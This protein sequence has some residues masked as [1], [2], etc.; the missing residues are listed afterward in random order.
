ME[1]RNGLKKGTLLDVVVEDNKIFLMGKTKLDITNRLSN[2]ERGDIVHL[3]KALAI[4]MNE[5]EINIVK[6]VQFHTHSEFSILDGMSKLSAIAKKS[7]GVTAVTDHGNMYALLKW[8][9]EMKK[10]GKKAIFGEE[11]YVET[12]DGK[13]E[14]NHLILLA[15]DEIGKKNL[16]LL[17]SEAFYAYQKKPHVTIENLKKYHEGLI[18]TS[19]CL[20]GEI[21]STIVSDYE[22]AKKVALFYKELFNEDFYLEIQ[23]HGATGEKEANIL[24]VKLARELGIKLVAANDSHYIDKSDQDS[25]EILLCINTGKKMDEPHFTFDGDGYWFKTDSEMVQDFWDLPEAITNTYEIA[26]KCNLTIETGVYHFPVFPTPEEYRSEEEF[27]LHL[28]DKGYNERFEGTPMFNNPE[29][30]NRLEHEKNVILSMG[31]VGYFL[32][33]WDYVNFA[34]NNGILVGPGRGSAAGSL[35]CY[36][37]KITDLEP[38]RHGLLFERFLNP[39]RLSMPDID[40]DFEYERRQEVIDYV[41]R[42]YGLDRVCNIITFGTMA[43]KSAV[44]DAA[45]VLSDYHLGDVIAK[46]IPAD[47]KNIKQA[48]EKNPEFTTSYESDIDV[49]AVVDVAMRIEN[50]TRQTSVHACGVVVADAPI[51]NYLPTALVKDPNNDK[52][53]I[54]VSQTTMT[55]VEELGL[56]KADFLGLRTMSV[57]GRSLREINKQRKVN[58]LQEIGYY[59]DIPLNDPYV[60]SEISEG[61]SFAVFQIESEGMRNFMSELFEDV[62]MKI[63]DIE[64]TYG[65]TGFGEQISGNGSDKAGYITAMSTFGDELFERMIAGVSLYRPGPMDYIPDYIKGIRNPESIT[66]DVPELEPILKPTYGVIVYQEQVMEIVRALAGFTM[67]QSDTVRKAMGKK[68][69]AILDEYCPY[70]LTGSGD[71]V[72]EYTGKPLNIIGCVANGISHVTAENIWNKMKKF[73][74]YAFN[75]SHA[76]VYAVLTVVCAWLKHY[77]REIY[78]CSMINTYSD[79]VVKLRS[80]ISTTKNM[81][82]EILPP[83]VNMS[84]VEFS[85]DGEKIRFGF[86]GIKNL[87]HTISDAVLEREQ[88]G[89]FSSMQDFIERTVTVLNKKGYEALIYT[90]ALDEYGMSRAAKIDAIEPLVKYAIYK[91]KDKVC[92][93]MSLFDMG[94]ASIGNDI[95]EIVDKK[96]FPKQALLSYEKDYSAMYIT[97]HPLD[98]YSAITTKLGCS[99]IGMFTVEDDENIS[100]L[101][102]QS[103]TFAGMITDVTYRT[104]KKDGKMMANFKIEDRSSEIK[105]VVFPRQ[106]ETVSPYLKKG[107]IIVL[108]G[109]INNDENFGLQVIANSV[110]DIN[111]TVSEGVSVIYVKLDDCDQLESLESLIKG[112]AGDVPVR[113]QINK[114]LYPLHNTAVASSALYMALQNIYGSSNVIYR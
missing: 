92:G 48:L 3:N 36:C 9:V 37:L 35:V 24:I 100:M 108:K 25:H 63:S 70:F 83:S 22:K 32:I 66:Y 107:N 41:K 26:K 84:Q 43:A 76:A 62:K 10:A 99:E 33:V 13:R 6:Y 75:K 30:R 17:S 20:G 93:Q 14:G 39:D 67:G 40:L 44:R 2:E 106:Y 58:G 11:V 56:L 74:E 109:E 53:K 4:V 110:M 86:N 23:R 113:V 80:Y 54:L 49:K 71:N 114:Q 34:K 104:T 77:H 60:Y 47:A 96:E 103:V 82:I 69:Q 15:K 52:E 89:F 38:I 87:P 42:K 79:N 45:R 90:G 72:D 81:G 1:I 98:E 112:Y 73:A 55:E 94:D 85:L 105:V 88:N 68:K 91:N 16:F 65:F 102:H 5:N 12:L 31:F 28:I 7:S 59:R 57:I 50:N 51:K 101:D 18:C 27:L 19:A 95:I 111:N 8:Q 97:E 46:M 64:D 78:M 21:A 61:K 29:Y